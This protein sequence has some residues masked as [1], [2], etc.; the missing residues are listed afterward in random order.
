MTTSLASA[1]KT[2]SGWQ[3]SFQQLEIKIWSSGMDVTQHGAVVRNDSEAFVIAGA[4]SQ[5]FISVREIEE[6]ETAAANTVQLRLLSGLKML[7]S[8]IS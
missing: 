2:L 3:N 7:V 4:E 8:P 6:V 1:Q 5:V